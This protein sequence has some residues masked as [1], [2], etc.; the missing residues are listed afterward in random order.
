MKKFFNYLFTRSSNFLFLSAILS[1]TF[2]ILS[3]FYLG[4]N[5]PEFLFNETNIIKDEAHSPRFQDFTLLGKFYLFSGIIPN[6]LFLILIYRM[7]KFL[8]VTFLIKFILVTFLQS[9]GIVLGFIFSDKNLYR[10]KE[11][12]DKLEKSLIKNKPKVYKA[13][14]KKIKKDYLMPISII[15]AATILALAILFH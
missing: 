10:F 6:S 15:I 12:T 5:Y 8:L 11:I 14:K 2:L 7:I 3:F 13:L 1:S 9:L 4:F